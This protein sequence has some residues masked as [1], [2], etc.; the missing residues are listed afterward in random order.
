MVLVSLAVTGCCPK[1]PEPED[2]TEQPDNPTKEPPPIVEPAGEGAYTF[3]GGVDEQAGSPIGLNQATLVIYV[4]ASDDT[5]TDL[6]NLRTSEQAEFDSVSQWFDESSFGQVSFNYTHTPTDGWYQL[7]NTYD[8]YMWTNEDIVAAQA[9]GDPDAIAQAERLQDLVQDVSGFFA[10]SLQ[11]AVD[12]GINVG[13]FSQVAVVI[14]GPF[15]RG[16]SYGSMSLTLNDTQGGTFQVQ[17]PM[18]VVSTS[19]GWQR[20]THEFGHAFGKFSDLYYATNRRLRQWDIMDC[21]DCSSQ[22]T[23]WHKEKAGWYAGAP[24]VVQVVQRPTG[25]NRLDFTTTLVPYETA[26][27][28][29]DTVHTLRL[30]VGGDL[31]LYVENRRILSDPDHVGDPPSDRVI[32]TD[33]NDGTWSADR[34]PIHL[35]GGPLDVGDTFTDQ[36]YGNLSISVAADPTDSA[37]RVVTVGWGA[38][39]YYDLRITPWSPPPWESP[40]IWIDSPHNGIGTFEF[41]DSAGQPER[42]GDRPQLYAS[43]RV[44][45]RVRNEGNVA[46]S[47]VQVSFYVADPAGIGDAGDWVLLD[48]VVI[49]NLAPNSEA[50]PYVIWAPYIDRHTC[51]IVRIDHQNA[52]LNANNNEA[53]ENVN[54]FKTTSNSPWQPVSSWIRVSNP[55]DAIQTVRLEVTGL[56]KGWTATVNERFVDLKPKETRNVGYTIDPGKSPL[57]VCTIID[58]NFVGYIQLDEREIPLGGV[59]SVVNL[60]HSANVEIEWFNE[61]IDPDN[62]DDDRPFRDAGARIV[63]LS[64]GKVGGLAVGLLL[65]DQEGNTAIGFNTTDDDGTAQITLNMLEGDLVLQKGETYTAQAFLYGGS[66]VDD[67]ASEEIEVRLSEPMPPA[68]ANLVFNMDTETLQDEHAFCAVTHAIDYAYLEELYQDQGRRF[69]TSLDEPEFDLDQA[70]ECLEEYG[71]DIGVTICTAEG[72]EFGFYIAEVITKFLDELGIQ[73]TDI[74]GLDPDNLGGAIEAGDCDIIIR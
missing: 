29:S 69:T 11:E 73:V 33:G 41:T 8:D 71:D 19:T 15:H 45:A 7:S 1:E 65:T 21:T 16:T 48:R 62:P 54:D 47:N 43:N 61:T 74:L 56:P 9:T 20:T 37:N 55:T 2:P 64:E 53:Q 22:T 58:V 46:A 25:N 13:T 5:T 23:G 38:D 59:T 70:T 31:H 10:D 14:I 57:E 30:D 35:F 3:Y 36:G 17:L 52:E 12:D 18:V 63:V 27:P 6:A 72:D 68:E 60:V 67:A 40:D 51:I 44:Y 28:A 49:P 34:V 24:G 32:I 50:T 42:N 39:P 26:N 4:R 66:C